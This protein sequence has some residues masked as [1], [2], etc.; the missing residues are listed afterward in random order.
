MRGLSVSAVSLSVLLPPLNFVTCIEWMH[1]V[2]N[3]IVLSIDSA[4]HA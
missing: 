3:L 4:L 1:D 2:M